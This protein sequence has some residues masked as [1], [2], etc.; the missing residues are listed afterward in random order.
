MW[1]EDDV[2]QYHEEDTYHFSIPFEYIVQSERHG[3]EIVG[4]A[5]MEVDL[6]WGEEA[7]G[8][9]ASY[10]SPDESLIDPDEGNGDI[11]DFYS[12]YVE[13]EVAER[14]DE[15]GVAPLYALIRV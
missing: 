11:D 9:R 5:M 12:D 3:D 1:D 8:Y 2:G 14:L 10:Y 4:T 15:M 6:V 7:G 13:D